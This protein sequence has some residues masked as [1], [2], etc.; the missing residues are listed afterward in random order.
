MPDDTITIA[1]ASDHAG[2]PLK[3]QVL[4]WLNSQGFA[5]LDC[6]TYSEERC[7]YPVYAHKLAEAL[8]GQRA[9]FGIGICGTGNGISMALNRHR[10]IRAALCWTPELAQLAHE[11][12]NANVLTLPGRFMTLEQAIPILEAFF[13]ATFQAGRHQRRIDQLD[14]L[15]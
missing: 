11:H 2:Y 14:Q 7:D 1:L 5:T 10:G 9:L 8:R 4:N 6:G 15:Q 13:Q 3:V 12:N